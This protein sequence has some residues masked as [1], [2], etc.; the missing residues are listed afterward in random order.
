MMNVFKIVSTLMLILTLCKGI[1]FSQVLISTDPS[2]TL[3]GSAMLEIQSSN[4][5]LLIPRLKTADRKAISNP[6]PGL[7][8]FDSELNSFFMY[9]KGQW[10]DIS[11]ASEIWS[12]NTNGVY[13]SNTTQNLGVGI[14]PRGDKKVVI[15]ANSE[16]EL[17]EPLFE[18][19]DQYGEPIFVVTSEGARVYVKEKGAKG[20]SG[21]FAVGKYGI[22]KDKGLGDLLVVN[23]KNTNVYTDQTAGGGFIVSDYGSTD[24]KGYYFFT[25]K[26][27]T[28]VYA[29]DAIKGAAGGFAVGKYGI[30]KKFSDN[31]LHVTSNNAFIGNSAGF[32]TSTGINNVFIGNNTGTQNTTG[33]NN[34]FIGNLTG[35]NAASYTG[36]VFIGNQ[37]GSGEAGNNKL[38]IN[39]GVSDASTSL[40]YGDFTSGS[41]QVFLNGALR[42][43]RGGQTINMPTIR[44][45]QFEVLT[46]GSGGSTNWVNVNTLVTPPPI[47]EPPRIEVTFKQEFLFENTD[48]IGTLIVKTIENQTMRVDLPLIENNVGRIIKIKNARN[49]GNVSVFPQ[50]TDAIEGLQDPPLTILPGETYTF[51][52]F[53]NKG[54][55]EMLWY[56]I[57]YTSESLENIN[58]MLKVTSNNFDFNLDPEGPRVSTLILTGLNQRVILPKSVLYPNRTIII[59]NVN[60]SKKEI[61]AFD[62]DV[63]DGQSS[64]SLNNL[65]HSIN[66]YLT[67][68]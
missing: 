18:V 24:R 16:D 52:A 3:D 17:T 13:L 10:N 61:F 28:R 68:K 56:I 65:L 30:A 8:V 57:D 34:I 26:D 25:G 54:K 27:S 63:I 23:Y 51:Q 38:Y 7:L 45:N 53:F 36:N 14:T 46:M 1:L 41:E 12:Q 66:S 60:E 29:N 2:G 42:F 31:Y 44:G 35:N 67:N 20:S 11:T 59:K 32:K 6:S 37:A 48:N 4:K 49:N 50:P 55:V 21:G 15:R 39:N 9:G 64:I 62:A 5:G 40:I 47:Y 58:G 22:A 33:S 43:N 19:Q